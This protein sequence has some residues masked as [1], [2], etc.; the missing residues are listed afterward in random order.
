MAEKEK[1]KTAAFSIEAHK[2]AKILSA[3][4]DCSIGEVIETSVK[5]AASG[6]EGLI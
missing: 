3:R 1:K 2:I 6:I 4:W 5:I